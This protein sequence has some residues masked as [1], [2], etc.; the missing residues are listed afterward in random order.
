MKRILFSL[1]RRLAVLV[2]AAL[3]APST[4]AAE[5]PDKPIRMIVPTTAGSVPDQVARW[6]GEQLAARLGQPI[7]VDNRPGAGGAIGLAAVA[8]APP[9]G[10]TLGMQALPWVVTP[11]LVA[12]MPYDTER[13]FAPVALVAWSNTLLVVPAV[14]PLQSVADIVARAKAKPGELKFSSAGIGTPAHL[15]LSLLEHEAAIKLT[16]VPYTGAPASVSAVAGGD[17]D[18]TA[19]SPRVVLPLVQ[20]GK[21]R[22][23]ATTSPRRLRAFPDVPTL[24]ELG[25]RGVEL[26]DWQ[27]VVVPAAVPREVVARL[28]AAIEAV[29]AL[30][31]ARSR[32]EAM[33]MEPALMNPDE[34][35]AHVSSEMKRW[36]AVVRKAGITAQ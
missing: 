14:S 31:D 23:L 29:L 33:G 32:L 36:S 21:L 11:S 26:S 3:C 27:G 24:V 22:V 8:S 34:F 13:D 17:T 35:A 20:A 12:K 30:P 28:H 5:Y 25:H 15:V 16:H 1:A 6:L 7:V 10:Y 19:A 9:D 2:L 4:L 18:L